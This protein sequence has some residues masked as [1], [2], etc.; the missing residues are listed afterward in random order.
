MGYCA[1]SVDMDFTVPADKVDAALAALNE[2]LFSPALGGF[3]A[4]HPYASL[5]EAVEG[6]TGFMEC[7][8]I[9][10]AFV[11]GCHCDKYCS[12]T[13]D[14]LETLA[15][16]AIE[17]SYVR[18]IGEDDRLFGFRVVDGRLRA[19]SGGFSWKV[20]AE[21]EVEDGETREY[22][23]CWVIDVDAASPTEAARKALAIQRN[24]SSIGTVFDVQRYEGMTTRGR[25]LGPALE[26]NLSAVDDV[27]T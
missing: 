27:S 2:V 14:V 10:G 8:D 26:I 5:L 18:F 25:Q 13:D 4:G 7:A 23:V 21:A 15:R 22:R 20:E 12:V 11:L 17:G 9:G 1:N 3:S 16:F 6:N 24:R 19:E